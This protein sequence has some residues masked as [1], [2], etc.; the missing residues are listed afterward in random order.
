[1]PAKHVISRLESDH[2]I[3]DG[4]HVV[5]DGSHVISDESC[6]TQ[7]TNNH[8]IVLTNSYAGSLGRVFL[9]HFTKTM[10]RVNLLY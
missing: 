1:M 4:S 3:L 10:K 7:S 6:M 2:V 5:S 8:E 9:N